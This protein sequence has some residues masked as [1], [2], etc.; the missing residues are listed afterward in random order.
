MTAILVQQCDWSAAW[1]GVGRLRKNELLSIPHLAE[2]DPGTV[3]TNIRGVAFAPTKA[4]R[5]VSLG[6]ALLDLGFEEV[7]PYLAPSRD[8][9]ALRH[10]LLTLDGIGQETADCILLFASTHPS[11]VVDEYTRRVFR[12]LAIFPEL[13]DDFWSAPYRRLQTFFEEN[14]LAD[15]GLYDG[16][17]FPAG[18]PREVALFRDFHAQIVELGKHHCL[19]T[20]PRC[21]A[22]GRDGWTDYA[23]CDTHCSEGVCS[24]C[25]L[26]DLCA[27]KLPDPSLA[28]TTARSQ[29]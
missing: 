14:I 4:K 11:F 15:M 26:V 2:A 6:Q 1:A 22:P 21:Q 27:R 8:K 20:R 18:L 10:E 19:R 13:G 29:R 5:L 7:E 12:R 28:V 23:F 17:A 3:E 25:P 24:A 16:F 9:V